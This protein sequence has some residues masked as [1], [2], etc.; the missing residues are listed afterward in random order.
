MILNRL[1]LPI[2]K[3]VSFDEDMDFSSYRGDQYHVRSISSCHL[4]LN[5]TN[6]D[7]LIVLDFD[8]KG[9]VKTTCA[10]TLE[11]IP[12]F[13]KVK[14]VVEL[15]GNDE[16]EFEIKGENIDIDEIVLTLI[17][18]S[19]PMKV[20]KKGATLPKGGD[21]YRVLSEEDALKEKK[22]SPFDVLDNLEV[23]D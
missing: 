6:Y 7:E 18:A 17:V 21:G 13:Y 14:E 12:Y 19:V 8:I 23:D 4:K 16:D 9:E 11:E 5:V 3:T 20:V 22:S 15:S 1:T 10:Y 2:G